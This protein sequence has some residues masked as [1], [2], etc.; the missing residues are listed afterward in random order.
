MNFTVIRSRYV[1][2]VDGT[3]ISEMGNTVTY[4]YIDRDKIAFSKGYDPF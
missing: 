2:L 1:G 3:C 4:I